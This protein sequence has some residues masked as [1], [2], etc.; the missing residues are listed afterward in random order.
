MRI[1]TFALAALAATAVTTALVMT[2]GPAAAGP[3]VS[4]DPSRVDTEQEAIARAY[5]DA[6]VTHDASAVSFAPDATRVEAGL[7]T[8][9][10]GAQLRWDLD[11]GPQYRVIQG[12]RELELSEQGNEVAARFLLDAGFGSTTLLTVQIDETF[13][14]ENGAIKT[15]V[16]HIT[17]QFGS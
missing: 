12:I 7:K 10:N 4:A 3:A 8:G 11:H 9:F 16:A 1:R 2:A 5:I 13:T 6:L 14:I 17:P 15:I